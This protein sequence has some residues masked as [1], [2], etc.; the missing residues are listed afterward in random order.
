M[1]MTAV[2]GYTTAATGVAVMNLAASGGSRTLRS[3][4]IF[5]ESSR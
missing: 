5:I 4:M 1:G 2:N 3:T